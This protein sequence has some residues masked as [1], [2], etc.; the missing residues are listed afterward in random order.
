MPH[1]GLE[2]PDGAAVIVFEALAPDIHP[3]SRS[4]EH[5][6]GYDL[7]AHLEHGVVR[8]YRQELDR[9]VD[10][11]PIAAG[12]TDRSFVELQPG[13]R[14]LVP[15]GFRARLPEGYEGQIRV[16]SSIAWKKGLQVPNAPGT[17][18]ADYPD[19]WF[20]LIQNTSSR[21]QRVSHGERIAQLVLNRYE[22]LEWDEGAVSVSTDRVGGLGSTGS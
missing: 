10:E 3:P 20:I 17:V 11:R 15:T 9:I 13:D 18:D 5:S 12:G 1:G 14:A 6:A 22:V 2:K 19:E 7:R 16:R 21:P 4:T 8:I